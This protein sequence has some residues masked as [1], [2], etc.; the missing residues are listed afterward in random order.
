MI[1]LKWTGAFILFLGL[2]FLF[3]AL[4]DAIAL[5]KKFEVNNTLPVSTNTVWYAT[6]GLFA[7][8]IGWLLIIYKK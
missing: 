3:L 8:I 1:I 4:Q 2:I 5:P 6:A 7:I